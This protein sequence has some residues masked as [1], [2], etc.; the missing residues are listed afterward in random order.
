MCKAQVVNGQAESPLASKKQATLFGI[1]RDGLLQEM[2]QYRLAPAATMDTCSTNAA[3]LLISHLFK[4][5]EAT[6]DNP[7]VQYRS[8]WSRPRHFLP[9]A[10]G[11]ASQK[12]SIS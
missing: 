10:L 5:V 8:L 4:C 2:Q 9:V 1:L 11:T 6:G 7:V 3:N 12:S